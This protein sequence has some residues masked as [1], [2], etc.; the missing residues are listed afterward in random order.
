MIVL[1][2]HAWLWW[3]SDQTRLSPAALRAIKGAKRL[4]AVA[5]I[6]AWEVAMLVAKGRIELDRDPLTWIQDALGLDK[7]ELMPLAPGI[8]VRSSQLALPHGDPADR[9]IAATALELSCPL[10]T[11]DERLRA[12]PGL[13]TIW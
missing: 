13:K 12:A 9:L 2:T 5:A 1:D 7:V 4:R 8:A 6:S 11:R 3:A 10:V